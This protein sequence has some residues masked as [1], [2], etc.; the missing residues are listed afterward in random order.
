MIGSQA[1]HG[2][3]AE[4]DLPPLAMVSREADIAFWNDEQDLLAD[5]LDGAIGEL[6]MFDQTHGYYAQGVSVA[7]AIL[8][9][10][11]RGRVVPFEHVDA[12]EARAHCLDP[13]DLA[14]SKL[15]A[16]REKDRDFVQA[17]LEAN[18]LDAVI[19]DQRAESLPI[20]RIQISTIRRF[21]KR[22]LPTS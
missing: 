20:T 11:W 19:L 12:G 3:F 4:H 18:L 8:P 9:E 13:H 14:L 5:R 2:A 22:H 17:L 10:G 15:V 1:I 7:T 6:S 21:L 16:A